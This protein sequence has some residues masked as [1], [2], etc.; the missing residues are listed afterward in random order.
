MCILYTLALLCMNFY[1]IILFI[2]FILFLF[3]TTAK[4]CG[5]EFVRS[6]KIWLSVIL[7]QSDFSRFYKIL[8][9][10]HL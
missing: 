8:P 1:T 6:L 4:G 5:P 10:V 9:E 3:P 7:P 2:A